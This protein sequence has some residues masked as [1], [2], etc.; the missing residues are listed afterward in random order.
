MPIYTFKDT[1][2]GEIWE[3]LCSLSD[4][5]AYLAANPHVT[6]LITKA[7]GLVSS[8]YT[9]GIRNDDGWN[10]NLAR[11]AEAHPTS[12]I[13]SRYGSKSITAAGTRSAIQKWKDKANNN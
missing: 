10:E 1:S 13:A 3:E 11:I 2:T 6:T 7:P 4:R 12:E 5:E 9:S 8:Q